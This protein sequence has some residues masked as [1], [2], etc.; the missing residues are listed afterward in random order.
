[1]IQMRSDKKPQMRGVTTTACVVL[2]AAC[3]L[4]AG[5]AEDATQTD[6][7]VLRDGTSVQDCIVID[8]DWRTVQGY[9]PADGQKVTYQQASVEKI[10]YRTAPLLYK[11][12]QTNLQQG[13]WSTAIET[14]G[15]VLA[16]EGAVKGKPW[17]KQYALY[18]IAESRRLLAELAGDAGGLRKAAEAYSSLLQGVPE[19]KFKHEALYGRARCVAQEAALLPAGDEKTAAIQRAGEAYRGFEEAC[20]KDLADA[21]FAASLQLYLGQ[22][23]LG[24]ISLKYITASKADELTV[25]AGEFRKFAGGAGLPGEIALEANLWAARCDLAAADKGGADAGAAVKAVEAQIGKIAA[26]NASQDTEERLLV[27][28]YSALGEH[29]FSRVQALP[30]GDPARRNLYYEAALAYLR[31]VMLYPSAAGAEAQCQFAFYRAALIM[32]EL[33]EVYLVKR[34]LAEMGEKFGESDFWK[35]TASKM[36]S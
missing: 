25:L 27:Q 6:T 13:K 17:V 22:G 18:N 23:Q 9:R 28:A 15:Q 5:A 35:N 31:V 14:L 19:T 30:A 33:G 29:F 1:L 26:S 32:K 34:L 12:A 16:D 21:A 3:F 20:K 8:E 7:I 2:L 4:G 10:D 11:V 24:E 36:T